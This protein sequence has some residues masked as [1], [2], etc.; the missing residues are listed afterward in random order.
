MVSPSLIVPP[1][2]EITYRALDY[3]VA[4]RRRRAEADV[5]DTL[6]EVTREEADVEDTLREVTR[7]AD[8][9]GSVLVRAYEHPSVQIEYRR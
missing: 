1:R 9:D 3:P 6:R 2:V 7:D 8:Q 4:R 5:E